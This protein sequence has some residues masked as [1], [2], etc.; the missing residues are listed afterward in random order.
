M[1][2]ANFSANRAQVRKMQ[3]GLPFQLSH[4]QLTGG[5]LPNASH[6]IE[7]HMNPKHAKE[8]DRAVRRGKAYR[9][10]A[11]KIQGGKI[12][13]KSILGDKSVKK[14]AN[15]A[16]N[17]I[18]NK[19]VDKKV[20]SKK[21][22]NVAKEILNN[23]IEGNYDDAQDQA[24]EAGIN[25]INGLGVKKVRGLGLI[26]GS[27]MAK[28]HMA[29]VRAQRGGKVDFLKSLGRVAKKVGVT[30]LKTAVGTAI[31]TAGTALTGNPM[32]GSAGSA[33]AMKQINPAIDKATGSGLIKRKN[34]IRFGN[35][36][37][38]A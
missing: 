19:L 13:L 5:S 30:A 22:S 32:L 1:L 38:P 36:F 18:T 35:G 8:V 2:K 28:Q 14:V 27:D 29:K 23:A 24:K 33:I 9:M 3:K 26:K 15:K 12:T 21:Q 17:A 31:A 11:E 6:D 37:M 16:L 20:I 7:I 25:T 34:N 10:K 4:Q